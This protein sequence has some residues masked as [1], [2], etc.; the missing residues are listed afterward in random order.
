MSCSKSILFC[1]GVGGHNSQMNRLVERLKPHLENAK[2]ISLSDKKDA[3][4]W[5]DEHYVCG[6]L[7]SKHRHIDSL[8]NTGP[9]KIVTCLIKIRRNHHIHSVVSTGPGI[10]IVAALFYKIM[11]AKIVHVETWSRFKTRSLTGRIM[12]KLADKFYVQNESLVRL[13]PKAIYAGLL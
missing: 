5:A 8:L 12:Y 1:Y 4:D 7:R 11:G 10:C 3:P 13:Y 6:E 2:L 9:A